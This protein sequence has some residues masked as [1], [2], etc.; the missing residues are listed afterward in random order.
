MS[1]LKINNPCPVSLS[2]MKKCGD[3]FTCKSCDKIVID[4]RNKTDEQIR[5]ELTKDTCGIFNTSQLSGQTNYSNFR[6]VAFNLLTLFSFLGFN[7]SPLKAQTL[8]N[9][10]EKKI[11]A[12]AN[13]SISDTMKMKNKESNSLKRDRKRVFFRRKMKNQPQFRTIGT[14]SF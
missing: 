7:V 6:Q 11:E 1:Q 2:N 5:K 12:P 8:P 13:K 10:N 3:N 4:F 9:K 14:P